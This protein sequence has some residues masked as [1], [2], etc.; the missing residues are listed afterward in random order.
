MGAN[1]F[2]IDMAM[3][4]VGQEINSKS[5][6]YHRHLAPVV[7]GG[8]VHWHIPDKSATS[9]S[10]LASI[11]RFG[12]RVDSVDRGVGARGSAPAL[13]VMSHSDLG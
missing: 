1:S 13:L 11:V 9:Q 4:P 2:T 8:T 7:N 12:R 6:D 10:C 5:A 3:P